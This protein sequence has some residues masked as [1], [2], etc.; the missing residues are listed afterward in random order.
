[1]S[2]R[3]IS[4]TLRG[5]KIWTIPGNAIR[6]TADRLREAIFNILGQG[7]RNST[8]LDLY[9]GTGAFGIEALSRNATYCVFIDGNKKAVQLIGKNIHLC[10]LESRAQCF[11][12][13]ISKN[14]DCLKPIPQRFDMAFLDPPYGQNLVPITL[15]HLDQVKRLSENAKIII[16]HAA[17]DPVPAHV[18]G[19]TV[20]DRRKYGKTMITFLTYDSPTD[21]RI[22]TE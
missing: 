16:E 11:L 18:P 22:N 10:N 19:Y 14:L 9:S 7:I 15:Y 12:W 3:I 13:D 8:V 17:I 4:G 20:V 6:P 5:K 2:L 1:M 21:E